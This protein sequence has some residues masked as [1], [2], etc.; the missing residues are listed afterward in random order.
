MISLLNK[1]LKPKIET[2]GLCP[3][4]NESILKVLQAC[5]EEKLN[6]S[7]FQGYRSME[8]QE[9]I[10]HD[11]PLVTHANAGLSWHC[12]GLAAD[13]VFKDGKGQWTWDLK[14]P[15]S[16]LAE[17]GK[18]F[19]LAWGGDWK[20]LKDLDHFE[21]TNGLGIHEALAIYKAEGVEAVWSKV[22]PK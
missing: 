21:K 13:L 14:L 22:Y 9:K 6:V 19:G 8:M 16:Q 1:I 11:H 10:F 20:S 17:I 2:T 12:F 5:K 3:F 18:S 4:F 7:L 15:W